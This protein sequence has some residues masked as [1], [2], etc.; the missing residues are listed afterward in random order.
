MLS[1]WW[2]LNHCEFGVA[3]EGDRD[4]RVAWNV[5]E[6]HREMLLQASRQIHGEA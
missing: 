3:V 5:V 4:V 1:W 2:S 6:Q